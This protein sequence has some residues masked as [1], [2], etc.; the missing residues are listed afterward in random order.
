MGDTTSGRGGQS[1]LSGLN[2]RSVP[3]PDNVHYV[4]SVH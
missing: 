2:G 4:Y 1:R 3:D